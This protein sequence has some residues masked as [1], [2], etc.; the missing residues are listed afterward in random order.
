MRALERPSPSDSYRF[1]LRQNF[2]FD[3]YNSLNNE[4]KC[5]IIT[6]HQQSL[7][8]KT[9]FCDLILFEIKIQN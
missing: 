7:S 3:F 6:N 4:D 5:H 2:L 8:N 1:Q 9:R